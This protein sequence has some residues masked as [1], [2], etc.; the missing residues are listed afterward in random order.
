MR[1]LNVFLI[2]FACVVDFAWL[3]LIIYVLYGWIKEDRRKMKKDKNPIKIDVA[4][5]CNKNQYCAATGCI[6]DVCR[7]TADIEHAVHKDSLENRLFKL[8]KI[9]DEHF[10]LIENEV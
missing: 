1:V 10:M 6:S 9:S 5:V 8:H 2:I 4:Y 7:Y 3:S